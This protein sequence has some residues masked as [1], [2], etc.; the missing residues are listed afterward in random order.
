MVFG[1]NRRNLN[2]EAFYPDKDRIKINHECKYL[3]I[4]FYSHSYLGPSSKRPQI[5]GM[6]LKKQQKLESC[7][8][9]SY[10][11]YSRLWCC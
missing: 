1:R 5:A 4:D 7:A 9:N 10:P 8:R 3:G 2:Q 11:I 6:T